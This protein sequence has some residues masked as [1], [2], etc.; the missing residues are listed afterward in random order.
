[1]SLK[2][3]EGCLLGLACGDTVGAAVE[4]VPRGRFAPLTDM[5]GGGKFR[6]APGEIERKAYG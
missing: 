6:L 3:S 5:V 4:F 2:R 1:M